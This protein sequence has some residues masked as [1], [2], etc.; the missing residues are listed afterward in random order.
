MK[1]NTARKE[2]MTAAGSPQGLN[3]RRVLRGIAPNR[4]AITG[5]IQCIISINRGD[6][7]SA[8]KDMQSR[9]QLL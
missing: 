8:D 3:L 4:T 2:E 9:N 1:L 7:S 6:G 5:E